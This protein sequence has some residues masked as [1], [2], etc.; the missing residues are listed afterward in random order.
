MDLRTQ[1]S[2]LAAVLSAAIAA[3][4]GLRSRKRRVH[5][6]FT[7][8]AGTVGAWYLTA[9]LTSVAGD[10]G[11]WKRVHL[12]CAVLLPVAAVQFF[13]AFV[14]GDPR[15]A[16]LLARASLLIGGGLTAAIL[17][18]AYAHIVVGTSFFVFDVL[19]FGAALGMMGARARA[20]RSRFVARIASVEGAIR[21]APAG[22]GAVTA[23]VAPLAQDLL[24]DCVG[25]DEGEPFLVLVARP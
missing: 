2:L 7:L 9:F 22:V 14:A 23:A 4:V 5:W 13:R 25:L 6:L 15:H 3:S 12:T 8:F 10:V 1:T 18:P 16:T 21:F 17:T 20:Q 19:I 24:V 11:T